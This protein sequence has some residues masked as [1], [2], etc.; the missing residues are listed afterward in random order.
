MISVAMCAVERLQFGI[1]FIPDGQGGWCASNGV[2]IPKGR[3]AQGYQAGDLSGGFSIGSD[4]KCPYCAN[5][6]FFQCGSCGRLVCMGGAV[7]RHGGLW[8][9]CAWCGSEG[10]IHGTIQN[11]QGFGD[12]G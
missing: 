3:Q 11:L 6:S 8:I 4:Y 12:L 5:D 1:N 10:P 9:W 2:R 7:E